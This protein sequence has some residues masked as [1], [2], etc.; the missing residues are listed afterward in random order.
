MKNQFAI[1][2]YLFLLSFF[3]NS[4]CFGQGYIPIFAGHD[5]VRWNVKHHRGF[6]APY[7]DFTTETTAINSTIIVDGRAFRKYSA[8][9]HGRLAE[10]HFLVREDTVEQ[11]VYLQNPFFDPN[12]PY[13]GSDFVIYDFSLE[14]GDTF[15]YYT[16]GYD[17]DF[18]HNILY[19]DICL[20]KVESVEILTLFGRDRKVITFSR[21]SGNCFVEQFIEGI[22]SNLGFDYFFNEFWYFDA[23]GPRETLCAFKDGEQVYGDSICICN[24]TTTSVEDQTQD[25]Q[26]FLFPNPTTN[27]ISI[28]NSSDFRGDLQ[29]HL[30]TTTGSKVDSKIINQNTQTIDLKSFT[31]GIYFYQITENGRII[32]SDK[33]V[34]I[35]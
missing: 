16:Y 26:F 31:P 1:T 21:I 15:S 29:W 30:F 2:K 20:S 9:E 8:I 19:E 11:K 24:N 5:S 33:L 7:N 12:I 17:V 28:S 4:F 6:W 34:I 23:P 13:Y 10:G 22:G 35:R 27:Q 25:N 14:V 3:V 18:L 32:Q